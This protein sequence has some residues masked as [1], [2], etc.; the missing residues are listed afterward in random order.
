MVWA[1]GFRVLDLPTGLIPRRSLASLH[2]S[3]LGR[4]GKPAGDSDLGFRVQGIG[5][6]GFGD[7]LGISGFRV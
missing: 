4:F 6:Q 7:S 3:P 5:F 2:H 1:F